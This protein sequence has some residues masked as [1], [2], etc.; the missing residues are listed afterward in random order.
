[1]R[2][3]YV[4]VIAVAAGALLALVGAAWG[5]ERS[6]EDTV[7]EGIKIGGVD[8]GGLERAAAV[9]KLDREL[10]APLEEPIVVRRWKRNWRLT[11]REARISADLEGSVD[12]ALRRSQEGS[13]LTRAARDIT[14]G[15]VDA[16][17][18]PRMNYS[19]AAVI[20]LVDRVRR[21]LN[22]DTREASVVFGPSAVAPVPSRDGWQ[23]RARELH[24]RV[25]EAIVAP[26]A[27]RTISVRVRR[28]HPK[29]STEDLAERYPTIITVDRKRFRLTL[30]K[31]LR[32]DRTYKIAVGQAGLETPAGTY[33]IND[34]QTNPTWHVPDSEWAG[35]LAG[36]S[37]PPG[38]DN[39][40][41]ARWMGFYDGA[42]I[43]GTDAINSLGTAASHGCVRMA[44]KDVVDLYDRV[45]VGTLI[46]VS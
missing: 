31:N 16:A 45:D 30:F 17:I 27:D 21:D 43:H 39:P 9:R 25:R 6:R 34:K 23:V 13:F 5:Y 14:G 12:A 10:L 3:R 7:A 26:G 28:T 18:E 22:R 15:E 19:K 46:H 37:I 20:R 32:K 1:L 2:R 11:A 24:R 33:S 44:I 4:I 29:V 8:V 42:G 36:K 38:P 35:K 40:I 41:K